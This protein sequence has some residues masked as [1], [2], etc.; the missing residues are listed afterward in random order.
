MGRIGRRSSGRHGVSPKG[1]RKS[2]RMDLGVV[3]D[4][5]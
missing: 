5:E 3:E 4:T 1:A 2:G